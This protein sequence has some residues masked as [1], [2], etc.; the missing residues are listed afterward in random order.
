M[1]I[2]HSFI[3][4]IAK[5]SSLSIDPSSE[6]SRSR[7]NIRVAINGNLVNNRKAF[8]L[9]KEGKDTPLTIDRRKKWE[10]IGFE[11]KGHPPW[12]QRRSQGPV[13]FKK[14]LEVTRNIRISN[15]FLKL[16]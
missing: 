4:L 14:S 1:G 7:R 9:L 6:W 10:S 11:F 2:A 16:H 5:Y 8:I 13:E 3:K 12:D 15:D